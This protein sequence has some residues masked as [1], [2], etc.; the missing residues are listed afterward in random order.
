MSGF[1]WLGRGDS[2]PEAPVGEV[3]D[4][5]F[6]VGSRRRQRVPDLSPAW[7]SIDGNDTV[8]FELS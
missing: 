8:C 3:F 1:T 5:R 6:Q 7:H 2:V 4:D